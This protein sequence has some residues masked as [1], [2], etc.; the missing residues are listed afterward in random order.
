MA[1]KIKLSIII[2]NWN[3][4]LLLMQCIKSIVQSL[5]FKV[6]SDSSKFKVEY[7]III[8]DNGSTDGSIEEIKKFIVPSFAEASAGKHNSKFIVQL[9]ENHA[10]LGFA[11]GN[12]IGIKEAKG[13]YIMLLNSDTI[14]KDGSL[15]KLIEFLDNNKNYDIVGPRL[16]NSDLTVQAS[17]GRFPN[18]FVTFIMLF[19]EHFNGRYV[20]F[21]PENSQEVEWLMGAA[22]L[23]RKKV[24]DNIDGLDEKIFMYMEEIEWFYRARQKNIKTF[25][26][27]DSEIIHLGRGSSR[28]GKKEPILHIYRGLIYFFQKH[29]TPFEVIIV[30]LMLKLKAGMA[31]F[32]GI[33]KND[34]YLIETYGEAIKIN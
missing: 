3:T 15:E 31:Y 26:F 32:F 22:I 2:V 17:C 30:K 29:K 33:I 25:F 4:K 16:L 28:S 34:K 5:K 23:A 6:Q 13:E 21:S 7:E 1:E 11:K 10:N 20:M 9:I 24:F 19:L 8:V 12:N 27:K 14:V 18:L